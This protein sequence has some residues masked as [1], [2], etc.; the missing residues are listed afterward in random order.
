MFVTRRRPV[1]VQD[2]VLNRRA[3]LMLIGALV[4]LA[5]LGDLNSLPSTLFP[6]DTSEPWSSFVGTKA[7]GFIS[8]IPL[9]LVVLGLWLALGAVR[10]RIGIPML[11]GPASRATSNDMLVAGLGLGGL[12]YA[13]N[14]V[15]EMMQTRRMPTVPS[16]L[17]DEAVP[18][19]GG[20]TGVLSTTMVMVAVIGIPILVVG[21]ITRKWVLR[22]LIVVGMVG[23]AIAAATAVSP[24]GDVEPV[25]ITLLVVMTAVVALAFYAWGAMSAWSWIVAALALQALDGLRQVVH[26]PVW[27]ERVAS[28]LLLIVACVLIGQVARRTRSETRSDASVSTASG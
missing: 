18:M 20:I 6:Y 16:T 14:R 3:T 23:L 4:V 5:V 22:A 2:G 19:L 8:S 12:V 10:R 21:G 15:G 17:L 13:A 1:L 25:R 28:G 24:T 26:A 27:Q 7:L 11:G 9:S